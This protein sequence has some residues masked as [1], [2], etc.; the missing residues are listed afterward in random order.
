MIV[1]FFFFSAS[2]YPDRQPSDG[3]CARYVPFLL[4]AIKI[5]QKML[6]RHQG[7]VGPSTSDGP[8]T[9]ILAAAPKKVERLP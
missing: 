5:R 6:A 1:L 8:T 3:R 9:P 4:G 2:S 7:C